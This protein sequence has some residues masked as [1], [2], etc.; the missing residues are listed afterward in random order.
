[1]G[2]SRSATVVCAY[3]I[4]TMSLDPTAAVEFVTKR[5]SIVSPNVG[6]QA[7]LQTYALR[8]CAEGDTNKRVTRSY[9]RSIGR[10]AKEAKQSEQQA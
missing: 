9:W 6:F 8:F 4:A 5:R 1:M 2:I 3:L 7:Q 10:G